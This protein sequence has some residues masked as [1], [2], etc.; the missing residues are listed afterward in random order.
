LVTPGCSISR[1]LI[2]SRSHHSREYRDTKW[3]GYWRCFD[4]PLGDWAPPQS[5]RNDMRRAGGPCTH[6]ESAASSGEHPEPAS[7][8]KGQFGAR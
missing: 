5:T 7:I 1:A 3:S 6:L 8:F 4:A 2:H